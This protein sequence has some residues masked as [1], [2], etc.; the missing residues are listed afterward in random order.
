VRQEYF[1]EPVAEVRPVLELLEGVEMRDEVLLEVV[2]VRRAYRRW[3][4]CPCSSNYYLQALINYSLC[5]KP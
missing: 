4:F 1:L 2:C 5:K 3:Y